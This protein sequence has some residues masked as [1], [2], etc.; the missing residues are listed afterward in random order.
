MVFDEA[1]Q[2][3]LPPSIPSTSDVV[4]T[5]L[6]EDGNELEEDPDKMI[7][8]VDF[9]GD[10]DTLSVC[11]SPIFCELFGISGIY[12]DQSF[13]SAPLS[14]VFSDCPSLTSGYSSSDES[15]KL[16]GCSPVILSS[17]GCCTVLSPTFYSPNHTFLLNDPS[18]PR[19]NFNYDDPAGMS[20]HTRYC[21]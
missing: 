3:Q 15:S 8:P 10:E 11:A 1:P 4:V 13:L 2:T 14:P 21:E 6:D 7:T 16:S 5:I 19:I 12:R 17:D 18:P 9:Y 20:E